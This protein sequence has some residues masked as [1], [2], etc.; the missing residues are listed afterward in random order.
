MNLPATLLSG[1]L[2]RTVGTSGQR[3]L[4]FLV[5][6]VLARLLT[7]QQFGTA[8]AAS[9]IVLLLFP[10]TRFGVYD[11]LL[12]RDRIDASTKTAGLLV[13]YL[14]GIGLFILIFI[15][16]PSVG[17]LLEDRTLVPALRLLGTIFLFAPIGAV[18]EGM[19][20]KQFKFKV[21]TTCQVVA[22]VPSA[23]VGIGL[24]IAGFGTLS[25]VMQQVTLVA[26]TS[27]LT[28]FAEPWRPRFA[29]AGRE[30]PSMLRMG[31]QYAGGQL[32]ASIN[33][34]F[35]GLAVATVGG[36]DAAG[37]FRVAWA[38]FTLCLQLT[39]ISVAMVVQPIFASFKEDPVR[40][41]TMFLKVLRHF[42]ALSFG[43]FAFVGSAAPDLVEFGFGDRW[44]A[45]GFP[46]TI[47]TLFVFAGTPNYLIRA[48]LSAVGR[49]KQAAKLAIVETILGLA[50][51]VPLLQFGIGGA[52]SAVVL[53]AWGILPITIFMIRRHANIAPKEIWRAMLVPL[54]SACALSLGVHAFRLQGFIFTPLGIKLA[55][56]GTVAAM[57]Y[58]SSMWLMDRSLVNDTIAVAA[59]MLRR[60][61]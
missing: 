51:V 49:P 11:Y 38:G 44:R 30:M 27:L 54:L 15:A 12:Q 31:V 41:R 59:R 43:V 46:L 36:T 29:G 9:M 16:A 19:L 23:I 21:I 3:L 52:A 34:N 1:F 18:Q 13:S 28:W 58:A 14:F 39:V 47:M 37:I 8:A 20:A 33:A 60:Q 45:A 32:F 55:L 26:A 2:W 7:V 42:A 61:L 24:A 17:W 57:A 5:L 48:Y 25:L 56:S 10:I 35:F 6:V 50:L 22:L 53:R 4:S 40:L